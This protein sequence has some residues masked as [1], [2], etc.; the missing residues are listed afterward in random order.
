M[1]C[2]NLLSD[3]SLRCQN[4]LLINPH[5]YRHIYTIDNV[6]ITWSSQNKTSKT[7]PNFCVGCDNLVRI[8]CTVLHQGTLWETAMTG[9]LYLAFIFSKKNTKNSVVFYWFLFVLNIWA[10]MITCVNQ[11][12]DMVEIWQQMGS[13]L[14]NDESNTQS[15]MMTNNH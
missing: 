15:K 11:Y 1:D 10:H 14:L 8:P 9:V 12:I 7:C 4:H 5:L 13:Y 6:W 3:N 2:H